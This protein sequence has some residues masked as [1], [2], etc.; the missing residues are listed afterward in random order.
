MST[1]PK[2]RRKPTPDETGPKLVE[3]VELLTYDNGVKRTRVVDCA[4]Q[5]ERIVPASDRREGLIDRLSE[6]LSNAV[7]GQDD[8]ERLELMLH[9]ARLKPGAADDGAQHRT[10]VCFESNSSL[11]RKIVAVAELIAE[12]THM[13]TIMVSEYVEIDRFEKSMANVSR[14]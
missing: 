11:E 3:R 2:S 9:M 1:S 10:T 14:H 13:K 12:L 6:A 8:V 4:G 5:D 7:A